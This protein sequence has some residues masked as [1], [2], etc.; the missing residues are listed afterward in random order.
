MMNHQILQLKAF[1]EVREGSSEMDSFKESLREIKNTFEKGIL[2]YYE[3]GRYRLVIPCSNYHGDVKSNIQPVTHYHQT[4]KSA[5]QCE[6]YLVCE[7]KAKSKYTDHVK[8][9][10]FQTVEDFG[11]L[12]LD[13]SASSNPFGVASASASSS[14]QQNDMINLLL[15]QMH[16]MQQ[17]MHN[18][19]KKQT[20]EAGPTMH[21]V[22]DEDE[23]F[24]DDGL[25]ARK[26]GMGMLE[27]MKDYIVGNKIGRNPISKV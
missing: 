22:D 8:V 26:R 23:D 18:M 15:G 7:L 6:Y 14:M 1:G 4:Y 9:A 25:I 13:A 17:Q 12:S 21:H 24:D 20:E 2:P 11:N 5:N 27:K 10:T 19:Q 3:Y 16:S